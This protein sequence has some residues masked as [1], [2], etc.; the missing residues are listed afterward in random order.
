MLTYGQY[1]IL[2][3]TN[4]VARTC[5]AKIS[6]SVTSAQFFCKKCSSISMGAKKNPLN[7]RGGT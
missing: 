2:H 6:I 3:A 7:C 5:N 1:K 4:D